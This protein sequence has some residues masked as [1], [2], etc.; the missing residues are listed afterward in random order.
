[1]RKGLRPDWRGVR[2]LRVNQSEPF[3]GCEEG[4]KHSIHHFG[5]DAAARVTDRQPDVRPRLQRRVVNRKGG[6]DFEFF[7]AHVENTRFG[8][9]GG[10][11][12]CA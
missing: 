5:R 3:F 7:Q 8:P 11:G 1:M 10:R 12:V 2:F 4:L 6:V 9:D